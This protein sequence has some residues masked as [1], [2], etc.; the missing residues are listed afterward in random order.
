VLKPI[1]LQTLAAVVRTSSFSQASREL[2]YTSSAVAQQIAALE[3]D[4]G[5]RLFIREPQRIRPT[6]AALL[7]AER[8]QHAL[9][10]LASLEQEARAT[11]SGQLGRVTIGSALDVG[12]VLVADSLALLREAGPGL[13]IEL[14]AGSSRQVLERVHVGALDVGLVYDY[15]LAPRQLGDAHV[16]ELDEAPWQLVTP[17]GWG[18]IVSLADLAHRHW[19]VGLDVPD[20][21]HAV[22]TLCAQ[23][24]FDPQIRLRSANHDLVLGSVAA[25]LGVGVVPR[26]AWKPPSG[27][28]VRPMKEAGATR[29]T[30]AVHLRRAGTP[31]LR[32]AVRALREVA[33]RSPAA[34]SE[35]TPAAL[36]EDA[37][38]F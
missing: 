8:G 3:R 28:L 11:A 33:R 35:K 26:L 31:A 18:A 25:G 34:T 9:D 36:R 12:S 13:E 14:E 30:V 17:A 21:E 15:P 6:P 10:L 23:A 24:G 37:K 16:I 22:R 32:A 27:V 20:G 29:L 7:L 2:G 38:K 5:V 4:L 1:H 19:F